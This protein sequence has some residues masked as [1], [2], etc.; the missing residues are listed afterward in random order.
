MVALPWMDKIRQGIAAGKTSAEVLVSLIEWGE[1]EEARITQE[2]EDEFEGITAEME[3]M[4]A[5][6]EEE[7]R[8]AIFPE[9]DYELHYPD[10]ED[11]DDPE[12]TYDY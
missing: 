9:K 2:L 6:P 5:V 10:D 11:D 8:P 7:T 4:E 12:K 3:S 1:A